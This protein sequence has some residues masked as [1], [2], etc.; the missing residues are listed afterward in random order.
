MLHWYHHHVFAQKEH[1]LYRLF[2]TVRTMVTDSQLPVGLLELLKSQNNNVIFA[3]LSVLCNVLAGAPRAKA[4]HLTICYVFLCLCAHVL[5]K[6]TKYTINIRFHDV[7]F[8]MNCS[9]WYSEYICFTSLEIY[10]GVIVFACI[11]FKLL[12]SNRSS[13]ISVSSQYYR[14]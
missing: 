6:I 8:S 11:K 7:L 5:N 9:Q 13:L 3:A 4:V 12:T 14:D 10:I 2:Q 1:S